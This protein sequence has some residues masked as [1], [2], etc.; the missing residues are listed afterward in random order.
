MATFLVSSRNISRLS[1]GRPLSAH[2][3]PCGVVAD[4][5]VGASVDKDYLPA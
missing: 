2:G 4:D 3:L 1:P 5:D